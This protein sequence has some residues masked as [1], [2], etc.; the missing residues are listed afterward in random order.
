ME[1]LKMPYAYVVT[2]TRTKPSTSG[3]YY[4]ML[5]I[6]NKLIQD[7][8]SSEAAVQNKNTIS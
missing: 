8:E 6:I 3:T 5:T 7:Q 1:S 4:L 2:A